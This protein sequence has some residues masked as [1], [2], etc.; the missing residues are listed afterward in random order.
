M[1]TTGL[2]LGPLPIRTGEMFTSVA[3]DPVTNQSFRYE[4]QL[5]KRDRVDACGEILDGWR[6]EGTLTVSGRTQSTVK[7]TTIVA[8]QLG[9][10][11]VYEKVEGPGVNLEYTL[12]Q[13][14]PSAVTAAP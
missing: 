13:K 6:V 9:M 5:V 3:V 12:G 2:L 10:I 7:L 8:P 11:P 4:A 1:P 14:V